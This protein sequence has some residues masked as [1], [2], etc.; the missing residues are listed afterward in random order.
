[1]SFVVMY[2][3]SESRIFADYTDFSDFQKIDPKRE[4]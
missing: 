3:F 2:F 1:M 4:I